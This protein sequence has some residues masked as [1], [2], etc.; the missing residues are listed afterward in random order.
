MNCNVA[1]ACNPCAKA[2]FFLSL[3]GGLKVEGWIQ[4]TYD[5]LDNIEADLSLLPFK[6]NAWQALEAKFKKAFIDDAVHER[7]QDELRKLRMKEGNVDK[8]IA[9][10][11]LLSHHTGVNLND[12]SVLHLFAQGLPKFLAKLCINIESSENF[13]QWMST[14]QRQQRNCLRKQALRSNY[15][16]PHPQQQGL[17]CSRFFWCHGNQGNL[18]PARP[19]LQPHNSNAMDTSAVACKATTK[20]KKEKYQKEGWCFECRK[21][22]HMV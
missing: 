12:P 2:A 18:Q 9:A 20:T 10:F 5:C 6:M 22:G 17:N 15:V 16:S 14:A 4:C 19:H 1:I 21:Q 8:Y 11:Q 3:I 7:A 13:E